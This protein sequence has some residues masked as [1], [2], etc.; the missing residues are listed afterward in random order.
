[1]GNENLDLNKIKVLSAN[2]RGL[3]DKNKRH[4]V[5]NYLK[6]KKADIICQQDTHLMESDEIE[7]KK[8]WHGTYILHGVRHNARGVAILFGNNFE[9]NILCIDKDKG[10]NMIIT[11]LEIGEIKIRLINIYGP[12]TNDEEFYNTVAQA[13]I[14]NDQD[15][16]IWCGD[17]NLVL[18]PAMDSN[19]YLN[20]NNSRH[21]NI[22]Y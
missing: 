1:M 5:L 14:A 19:N 15:Y 6:D 2:C 8:Y 4:D 13:I 12:N 20:I 3:K 18:N 16:L 9:Y 10:G 7:F 17:F 22:L 11:D 21:R